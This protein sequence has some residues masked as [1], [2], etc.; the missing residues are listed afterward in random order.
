M[1]AAEMKE[2]AERLLG[3]ALEAAQVLMAHFAAGVTAETKADRSPVTVADRQSEDIILAGLE[4]AAPGVPVVSEE[5]ASAGH[6]PSTGD[7]FFLVDPVD[8]TKSFIRGSP[9][10]T[11]NIALVSARRPVFGLLYAPAIP[12]FYVTTGPAEACAARLAPSA[13][14]R[15][16]ADCN[17]ELLRTRV[18]DPN[19]IGALTSHAHLNARTRQFLDRLRVQE[20]RAVSSSLKFGL[21]ARG[22]ADLYPRLGQTSE[23]D[24]AAGHAVLVAAG[25]MVT[26]LDETPLLYAKPGFLNSDFV[27]WGR[28]P[29]TPRD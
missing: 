12:D 1:Q 8:G 13:E 20:R 18:P 19:A 28:T 24:T 4:R 23:W 7:S 2:L 9:E 21:L 16:L 29:L 6:I 3:V 11:I 17:L 22:E 15:S 14:I 27:A 10:F 26:T 5:A 25:G